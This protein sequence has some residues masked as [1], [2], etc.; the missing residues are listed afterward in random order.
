MKASLHLIAAFVAATLAAL[1]SAKVLPIDEGPSNPNPWPPAEPDY[2]P[3]TH[4]V[5]TAKPTEWCTV[6]EDYVLVGA[7]S[8]SNAYNGD[9]STTHA[10]GLLCLAVQGLPKPN[11]LPPPVVTP[12]GALKNS[13]SGGYLFVVPSVLGT[14]LTSPAVADNMCATYGAQ[15]FNVHGARM[16]EFHDGDNAAGWAGWG[17]WARAL[18]SAMS[19]NNSYDGRLWIKINDQNSN[20]WNN[21]AGLALTFI[22]KAMMNLCG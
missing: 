14:D 19:P 4:E 12:G 15:K 8:H 5:P 7:D 6:C 17:F 13:W 3:P 11:G 18:K 22:K 1:G 9:T 21:G 20:P 2:P 10:G 16:A